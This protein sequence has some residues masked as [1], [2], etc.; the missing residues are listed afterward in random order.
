MNSFKTI[1]YSGGKSKIIPKITQIIDGLPIKTVL[2]GFSGSGTVSN[3][4]K[5][6]GFQTTANDLASYSK[7]L[8][9][10]F[11]LAKN[12][13]K[14]LNEIINHLNSLTPTDGW[15]TENYG[16]HY[17]NGS[18]IQSDGKKRPFYV[19]VTRKLDSIRDEIDKL[20]PIDCV[21]KS[22]LL[23]S[24]LL[25]LD[26]RC[27]D[28]GHQVSY[29]K[30][31]SRSSLKPLNLE[32]PYW[33]VDDLDHKVYN[34]DVFDIQDPFD[35]VY[36]D[37]PYGTS[38][39]QTK[40]T[41]VRYFSYYHLWTTIIKND[42]PIL[43]GASNRREDVSSDK[44]EGAISKFEDLKDDV[45][46]ESFNKLLDFNTNYTLISYSN[47][48]KLDISDLV[49]IIKNKHDILDLYEFEYKEN[50]QAN[51]TINSKYKINYSEKNK[52]YL[53]LSKNKKL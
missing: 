12:N 24:L 4:F 50:S 32:L 11:L 43:F 39:K 21:N 30:K 48:S 22:V 52:E 34:Q 28:M 9:E 25:A 27:N 41:R 23:T 20:Y 46:I 40:T 35:L 5:Y 2:D 10:T 44:K 14:E 42:K 31:W 38:N 51:S 47:R 29:L 3:H 19:D 17:N 6:L 37:P 16:G 1:R 53:I 8:S 26:P 33:K 18:T 15:F 49:D 7:V 36:F 45:V 13:K